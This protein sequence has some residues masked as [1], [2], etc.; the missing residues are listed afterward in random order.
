MDNAI[1]HSAAPD[2]QVIDATGLVLLPGVIVSQDHCREPGLEHKKDLST[3]GRICVI[4]K[5]FFSRNAQH[6]SLNQQSSSFR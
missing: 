4:G 5:H 2:M 6:P 3:A 1:A